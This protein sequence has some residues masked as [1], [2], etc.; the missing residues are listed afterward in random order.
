MIKPVSMPPMKMKDIHGVAE[1]SRKEGDPLLAAEQLVP[2][3]PWVILV[4]FSKTTLLGASALFLKWLILI[5]LVLVAAGSLIAWIISRNITRPLKKL[6]AAADAIA[7]GNYTGLVNISRRDELGKL[8][9]AFNIM[10]VEVRNA[11]RH[12]EN[13]VKDRT[14]E[15]ETANKELEAF[16]YSVSHDL[17]APLRII[18]GYTDMLLQK[19][20]SSLDADGKRMLDNIQ[21][22]A[23]RMRKLIDELLNLSYLGRKKLAVELVD[24]DALV[25]SVINDQLALKEKAVDI[26]IKHLEPAVCDSALMVQVWSNLLSNAIKYSAKNEHPCI[27]IDSYGKDNEKVYVVK[28][29]GVGFDMKYSDKLFGVFQRL[30]GFHEFEGSGIGLSLVQRVIEKHGGRVWAEGEVNKGA[31]FYFS[32][33]A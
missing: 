7:A 26:E 5:D 11:Q 19:H 8:A 20:A 28:D 33:R 13:K 3:S 17:H 31:T 29:N 9:E 10:A 1:Y 30:H 25:H 12:L 6:T 14:A 16:S 32:L 24:M 2:N 23:R 21:H 22:R 18:D 4:E 15:L 27:Q